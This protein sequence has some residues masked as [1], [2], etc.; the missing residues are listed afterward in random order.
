MTVH[1]TP[2]VTRR[3]LLLG[4]VGTALTTLLAACGDEAAIATA[5]TAL[6]TRA[7]G[8]TP[9]TASTTVAAATTAA[10]TAA[11]AAATQAPAATSTVA[12]TPVAVAATTGGTVVAAPAML[13]EVAAMGTPM[14]ARPN[15]EYRGTLSVKNLAIAFI[16]SNDSDAIFDRYKDFLAYF[17]E[18]FG[19][20]IKGTVGSSYSAVIEAMRAKK[21]DIAYYGPFSYILAHQE[22]NAQPLVLPADKDG[23]LATYTSSI[24]TTPDSPITTLADIRGKRMSFVDA[25]STSG[26]LVPSY[27]LLQKAGLRERADFQFNYAGSHPAS[28]QA[29]IN[30]KV[31]AGAVSTTTLTSGLMTGAVKMSEYKTI[32]LSFDIPSSPIA[33]RGDMPKADVDI[34]RQFY[35]SLNSTPKDSAIYKATFSGTTVSFTPGDDS[36][37]NE[38]RKIPPVLG[39]DI[40]MLD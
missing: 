3:A 39:I 19:I 18:S 33:Y 32:D 20:E 9:T 11:T 31:D 37:Y 30:K 4:A 24:I 22:A 14:S 38:L 12:A 29:V 35:L 34:L 1:R 28:Y 26:H 2:D 21:V 25:A 10:T 40:K 17:K 27:T 13:R 16:P 36:V 6:P 15:P 5:T 23:K 7:A 8:T